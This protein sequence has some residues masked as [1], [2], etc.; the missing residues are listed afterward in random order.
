[1]THNYY[2]TWRHNPQ[3]DDAERLEPVALPATHDDLLIAFAWFLMGVISTILG[4][5]M[6]D[7]VA[8]W[9]GKGG[10]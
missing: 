4:M 7:A 9:L 10:L 8:D 2:Y 1:M 5:G 3:T 6:I